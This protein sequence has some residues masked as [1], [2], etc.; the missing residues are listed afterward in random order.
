MKLYI[1]TVHNLNFI[2]H[3]ALEKCFTGVFVFSTVMI[4]EYISVHMDRAAVGVFL[5]FYFVVVVAF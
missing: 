1:Y 2:S 4:V 5:F 3:M